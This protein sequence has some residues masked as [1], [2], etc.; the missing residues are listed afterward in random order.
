MQAL[1]RLREKLPLKY[2]RNFLRRRNG[3]AVQASQTVWAGL[4]LVAASR[5]YACL[6]KLRGKVRFTL[7]ATELKADR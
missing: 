2:R 1:W 5:T 7:T 4:Q 3:Q 6:R